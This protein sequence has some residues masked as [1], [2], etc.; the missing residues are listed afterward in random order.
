MAP[1]GKILGIYPEGHS[2]VYS[3]VCRGEEDGL[4]SFPV[5]F[6]YHMGILEN[7]GDPIGRKIEYKDDIEPPSLRFLD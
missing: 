2:S 4:F 5:E 6:R 3:Y 7:E 1:T